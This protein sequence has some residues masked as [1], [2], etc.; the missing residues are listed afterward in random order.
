MVHNPALQAFVAQIRDELLV[1]QVLIERKD[2]GYEM[3]HIE[4]GDRSGFSLRTVKLA[5]LRALTQRSKEGAFRPLKSAPSLQNGWRLKVRD[6]TELEIALNHLYPGAISDWFAAQS[7]TAPVTH[8]RTFTNRQTGIYRIAK[9][10]TDEQVCNVA[11]ACCHRTFC[12]KRRLWTVKGIG[13]ESA[14][15]KS[16]IPCLEPCAIL[17][18]FARN[19]MRLEQEEK[20]PL[21]LQSGDVATLTAALAAASSQTNAGGREADFN[22]PENPRRARL[23]LEKLRPV[24]ELVKPSKDE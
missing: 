17:L 21:E 4:D 5:D 20:L 14:G 18:E 3:Q 23:L 15:E 10:L 13:P 1:G 12:L 6:D 9:L 2:G 24:S 11:R 8:Y 19:A 7:S 22:L 16:L